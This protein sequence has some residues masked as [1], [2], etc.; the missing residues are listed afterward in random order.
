SVV[1]RLIPAPRGTSIVAAPVAKKVLTLAGVRDCYT[2]T[3]GTTRT[4]GNFVKAT[5]AAIG[6]T[7][8][9]LTPDLWRETA[10]NV[11]PYQEFTDFLAAP[12]KKVQ[13]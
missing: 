2:S 12:A 9:F 11:A 4:L 3:S 6:N 8:S 5:F 10:L 7:Y 1:C 13:A